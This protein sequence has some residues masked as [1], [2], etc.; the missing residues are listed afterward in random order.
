MDLGS[1]LR[2]ASELPGAAVAGT[3]AVAGGAAIAGLYALT[4][5]ARGTVLGV[6]YSARDHSVA[7][8]VTTRPGR[9]PIR[10]ERVV[11]VALAHPHERLG[12]LIGIERVAS[13]PTATSCSMCSAVAA[14][15]DVQQPVVGHLDVSVVGRRVRQRAHHRAV[16]G[17]DA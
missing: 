7:S 4:Q 6:Q 14:T 1:T 10:A 15:N 2:S 13:R 9:H 16:L 8:V 11:E 5:D 12:R 17:V 3:V